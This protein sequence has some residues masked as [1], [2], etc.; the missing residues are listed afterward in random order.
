MWADHCNKKRVSNVFQCVDHAAHPCAVS[1]SVLSLYVSRRLLCTGVRN[2]HRMHV[3]SLLSPR[4]RSLT[5]PTPAE[6]AS[7][8][9]YPLLLVLT[10]E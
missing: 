9:R 8:V 5:L 10:L 7:S 4:H 6:A 1:T 2:V 3:D